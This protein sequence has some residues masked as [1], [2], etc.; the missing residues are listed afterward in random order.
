[1]YFY[2]QIREYLD[3]TVKCCF[4]RLFLSLRYHSI[5]TKIK[6]GG[7]NSITKMFLKDY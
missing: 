7:N 1:M 3:F 2:I 4:A 5:K 6:N